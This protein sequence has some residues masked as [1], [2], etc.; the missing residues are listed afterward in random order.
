MK[1]ETIVYEVGSD[2]VA[3]VTIN[4]PAA[5]NSFTAQMLRDF[6]HV[7]HQIKVDENVHAVVLRG[8][9][10]RAFCTGADIKEAE[11]EHPFSYDNLWN[12]VDPGIPLG[13]RANEVW[14]PVVTAVHGLC[15]GGAFYLLNESDI[16]I[17]SED[18]QFFDPHVSYGLVCAVEPIGLSYRMAL[19]DVMRIALLGNDERVSAQAAKDM[20]L[21]SEVLPKERLW[22]RAHEL[23]AKIADKPPA[24]IQGSVRAIWESMDMPRKAALSH[25]FGLCLLGRPVA[26]AGINHSEKMKDTKAYDIRK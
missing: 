8:A 15:C 25:A 2:H 11:K 4:R 16:I 14:K 19:G 22:A 24:A 17:C 26:Q 1:Y 23:A 5:M 20:R 7:W 21:V 13:P 6:Q 3:T 18:A 12:M 10:G 9:D